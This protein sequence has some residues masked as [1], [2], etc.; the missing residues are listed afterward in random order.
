MIALALL[1]IFYAK[2]VIALFSSGNKD[3]VLSLM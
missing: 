3:F 2:E 1:L